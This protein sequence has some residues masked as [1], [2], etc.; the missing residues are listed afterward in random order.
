MSVAEGAHSPA[1]AGGA[2]SE[3]VY[4]FTG[5]LCEALAEEGVRHVVVSPGS[6]S[7]PL[8]LAVAA[9]PGLRAWPLVDERSAGFFALGLARAT[10]APV[11][12]VCTSGSAA[13]NYLPAV[14]E[15][16]TGR[17]P[18]VLCTADRPPELRDRGAGQTI[19]Q[20]RLYGSHA[21]WF[22][23]LPVAGEEG[24]T[25]ASARAAGRRAARVARG[26]PAGPVHLN[27]PFR[28]PLEP[29]APLPAAGPADPP[30][31]VSGPARPAPEPSPDLVA[32]LVEEA[33]GAFRGLV[34]AG[35]WDDG[36][37]AVEAAAELARAAGWPLWADPT[38]QLRRL[39]GEA[40]LLACG[41]AWARAPGFAD[42]H[43]PDLVLRLGA[44]PTSKALRLWLERRPPRSLWLVDPDGAHEDPSGLATRVL[45][46]EPAALCRALARRLGR[47]RRRRPGAGAYA[48]ALRRADGRAGR[49]LS[50][51]LAAAAPAAGLEPAA[52]R[53][54]AEALPGD[55]ILYVSNSMP[56][57]DLDA[58]MPA[59]PPGVRVLANRG[60]NG[61][62]GV[63]SSAL[64]AAAA[65]AGPV[66]LLTGDLALLYDLG[67][68]L[69]ARRFTLPVVV[70]AL[71]NDGGGIFSMLPVAE[72]A[73]ADVFED[74]YRTPHGL[75][76]RH[77]AALFGLR[78]ERAA[79]P[80]A[81][82]RA[83]ERALA[84]G[85]AHLVE[86]P[87]DRDASLAFRREAWRAV[88]EAVEEGAA[89]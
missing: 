56:V 1:P 68:L 76:F 55:A 84:A 35:P 33:A 30:P 26:R 60:A 75:D 62:D 43:A 5:A 63:V 12:L 38:S 17:V 18:L 69:A 53:A 74:L 46:V 70:V 52:V 45:S 83:V 21:L 50:Q 51:R 7:T 87:L 85:G 11:A 81:V 41:D 67:G 3:P 47:R 59:G 4:A 27:L 10:R 31:A 64:G 72:R 82:R 57:R 14:V 36:P 79:E 23:E 89:P 37:D 28:E 25:P 71:H 24:A 39:A 66:V 9:T 44:P 15:A 6:R 54:V 80:A 22:A 19:D 2:L 78:F 73:P 20:L 48:R 77:A 32:E 8:V 58:W 16:R 65:G 34:V 13:A 42:R 86:V 49:V 29:R 61:I 88:A 40:P